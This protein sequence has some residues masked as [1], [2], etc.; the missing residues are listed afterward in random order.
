MHGGGRYLKDD[1]KKTMT[2]NGS[3]GDY[4]EPKLLFLN[5][6]PRELKEYTFI[7][8]PGWGLPGNEMDLSDLEWI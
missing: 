1:E 8:S 4:G 5:Q 6:I 7:F 3:S 2:L